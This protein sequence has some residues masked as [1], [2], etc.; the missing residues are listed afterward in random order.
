MYSCQQWPVGSARFLRPR[1]SFFRFD[2]DV[3]LEWNETQQSH[4]TSRSAAEKT[5][6][7][8]L[9]FSYC[10]SCN[11]VNDWMA[12]IN[13]IWEWETWIWMVWRANKIIWQNSHRDA[14]RIFIG[15][16]TWTLQVLEWYW[17]LLFIQIIINEMDLER[18]WVECCWLKNLQRG[19][20]W[21]FINQNTFHGFT[22]R[23][24]KHLPTPK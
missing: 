4:K 12:P 15:T 13:C 19:S 11:I 17:Y 20:Y 21:F 8:D 6:C 24:S 9:I 10:T 3:A 23:V 16:E 22:S 14:Q 2:S 7:D 1:T 5:W 18:K